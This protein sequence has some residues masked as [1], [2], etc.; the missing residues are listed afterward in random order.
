MF[1]TNN[2]V[3]SIVLYYESFITVYISFIL[4]TLIIPVKKKKI[5]W[6]IYASDQSLVSVP[7]E[8]PYLFLKNYMK[9]TD[10]N[11]FYFSD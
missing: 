2:L 8:I 11:S 9:Y 3:I 6:L 7:E 1:K 4:N 5:E 10:E